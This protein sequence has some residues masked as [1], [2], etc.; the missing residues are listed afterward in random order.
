[1]ELSDYFVQQSDYFNLHAAEIKKNNDLSASDKNDIIKNQK[2]W[3]DRFMDLSEMIADKDL[4]ARRQAQNNIVR[5]N[6][7]VNPST[8]SVPNTG[9]DFL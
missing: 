7:E 3:A 8:V 4:V 2:V 9:M 1:M 6:K 5:S